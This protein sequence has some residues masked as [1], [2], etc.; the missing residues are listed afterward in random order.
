MIEI[1]VRSSR[2][3]EIIDITDRVSAQVK[4]LGWKD[5]AVFLY[6]PHTTAGLTVNEGDDPAVASDILESLRRL[7]PWNADYRHREGNADAHI[8]ASLMGQSVL[9]PLEAGELRLGTWQAIFL[10]EFD[11]P[12]TRRVWIQLLSPAPSVSKGER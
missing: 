3:E 6:V 9:V 5:G 4:E 2:R 10:C 11:G 12:R 1:Q 8:K 7:A